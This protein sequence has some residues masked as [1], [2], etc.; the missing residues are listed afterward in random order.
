MQISYHG[1][2]LLS[3]LSRNGWE[4]FWGLRWPGFPSTAHA[5]SSATSVRLLCALLC[6]YPGAEE[7]HLSLKS[8]ACTSTRLSSPA[9]SCSSPEF[10]ITNSPWLAPELSVCWFLRQKHHPPYI[11][12]LY[13]VCHSTAMFFIVRTN[14]HNLLFIST[15]PGSASLHEDKINPEKVI[16]F[17]FCFFLGKKKIKD[18]KTLRICSNRSLTVSTSF[19]K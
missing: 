15:K 16:K 5:P 1:Q 9:T 7:G 17:P 18:E 6:S 8:G 12:G 14:L 13:I 19:W 2:S 4:G 11:L 3:N 10:V